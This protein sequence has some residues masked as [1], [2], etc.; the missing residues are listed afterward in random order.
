[1]AKIVVVLS[2]LIQYLLI[3]PGLGP[4]MLDNIGGVNVHVTTFFLIWNMFQ[5]LSI[6]YIFSFIT[7]FS[8]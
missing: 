8:K 4:A 2:S 5:P 1:M 6:S 7:C 3:Y